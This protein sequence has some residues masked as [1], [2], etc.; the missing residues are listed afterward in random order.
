MNLRSLL[1]VI[2]ILCS[3][4]VATSYGD[5]PVFI[6]KKNDAG[7]HYRHG[8]ALSW[9]CRLEILTLH[10][11]GG[12]AS[13]IARETSRS[14]WCVRKIVEWFDRTGLSS[15]RPITGRRP[16][17]L[18]LPELLYLKVSFTRLFFR[19]WQAALLLNNVA[20]PRTHHWFLTFAKRSYRLCIAV[21]HEG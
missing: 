12:T 17:K 9:E 14:R 13:Q 16:P 2:Y 11:G 19:A 15:P 3:A 20:R 7:G 4:T 10:V 18:R 21:A 5:P 1:S 6:H 8:H